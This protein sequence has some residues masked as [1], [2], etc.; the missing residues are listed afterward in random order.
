MLVPLTDPHNPYSAMMLSIISDGQSHPSS[1]YPRQ[2]PAPTRQRVP[3]R[4]RGWALIALAVVGGI[5]GIA[6]ASSA[7]A[8]ASS[9]EGATVGVPGEFRLS[10][11]NQQP[12]GTVPDGDTT[13]GVP[14]EFR[15]SPGNQQPVGTVPG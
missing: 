12:V 6:A 5:V 8:P 10:P 11:G 2:A 13:V 3:Q 7:A 9:G 4:A 1:P 15:L 14:G